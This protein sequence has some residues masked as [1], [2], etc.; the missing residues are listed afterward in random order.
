MGFLDKIGDF[1][2]GDTPAKRAGF[3]QGWADETYKRL[4]REDIAA[5]KLAAKK[6]GK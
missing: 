5:A 2:L 3:K 4:Q 1:V 6:V